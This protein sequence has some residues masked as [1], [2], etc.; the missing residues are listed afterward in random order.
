MQK[1]L[2]FFV[3]RFALPGKKHYNFSHPQNERKTVLLLVAFGCLLFTL[4]FRIV[5]PLAI[6]DTD[7]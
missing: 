6:N 5:M 3:E 4:H 1:I 2:N 7:K